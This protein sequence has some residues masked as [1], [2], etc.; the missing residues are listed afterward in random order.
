MPYHSLG[1]KCYMCV[2]VCVLTEL[3]FVNCQKAK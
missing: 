3:S 1:D 2:C